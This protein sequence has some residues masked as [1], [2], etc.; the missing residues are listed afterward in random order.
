MILLLLK[1]IIYPLSLL[2][3]KLIKL[4]LYPVKLTLQYILKYRD[5]VISKNLKIA[6]PN[7]TEV[8]YKKVK[9]DF[10]SNFYQLICESIKSFTLSVKNADKRIP[11]LN[12]E[13]MNKFAERN[14]EI[15]MLFGHFNNW[16]WTMFTGVDTLKHQRVAIYQPL[17]NAKI[18][19]WIKKNRSRLGAILISTK[20]VK[21]F[22]AS[23]Q[24]LVSVAFIADQSP[25]RNGSGVWVDF[26]N[27]KTFFTTGFAATA[28]KRNV[29]AV[30][31]NIQRVTDGY[32]EIT[33]EDLI[34]NPSELSIEEMVQKFATRL[35]LQIKENPGSWLWSH[36]RWKQDYKPEI[37]A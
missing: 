33:T 32:Y 3:L 14:Q 22:Y 25:A 21:D 27:R 2:P 6:F 29:P 28:K 37:E 1:I 8:F 18:N 17:K 9:R 12:P 30:F 23:N 34:P 26:F 11:T 5:K 24:K 13:G 15:I 36:N 10:Y 16:E 31:V 35:E 20:E 19:S 4:L 7:E